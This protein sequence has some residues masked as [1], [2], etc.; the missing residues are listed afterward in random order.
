MDLLADPRYHQMVSVQSQHVEIQP[1]QLCSGPVITIESL[2]KYPPGAFTTDQILH[3]AP[4]V[5]RVTRLVLRQVMCVRRA[6]DCGSKLQSLQ[7]CLLQYRILLAIAIQPS[8]QY[9]N[10]QEL[11]ILFTDFTGC[12]KGEHYRVDVLTDPGGQETDTVVKAI[13]AIRIRKKKGEVLS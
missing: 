9:R 1:A 2:V 13:T 3:H 12:D 4:L 11:G 5:T 10:L 6:S 7:C 8:W